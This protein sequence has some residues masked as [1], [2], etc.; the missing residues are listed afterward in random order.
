VVEKVTALAIL[1][2]YYRYFRIVKSDNNIAYIT[3][4]ATC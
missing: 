4:V 3:V 2:D 1:P